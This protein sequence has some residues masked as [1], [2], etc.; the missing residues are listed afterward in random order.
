MERAWKIY[1]N[2]SE[3]MTIFQSSPSIINMFMV[4]II[5]VFQFNSER[6]YIRFDKV[7]RSRKVEYKGT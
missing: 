6:K 5:R 3:G 7:A 2:A 4:V 1:C